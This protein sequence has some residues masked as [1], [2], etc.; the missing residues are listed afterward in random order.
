MKK[1]FQYMCD[2]QAFK[3]L[4]DHDVMWLNMSEKNTTHYFLY[5]SP[6]SCR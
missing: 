6:Y 3:K 4:K 1:T 5:N 2:D